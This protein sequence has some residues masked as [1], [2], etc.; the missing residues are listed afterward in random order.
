MIIVV[1]CV[2]SRMGMCVY[3]VCVGLWRAMLMAVSMWV[4]V[5]LLGSTSLARMGVPKVS[6]MLMVMV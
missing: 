2:P 4:S 1:V 5:R 6:V 3:V